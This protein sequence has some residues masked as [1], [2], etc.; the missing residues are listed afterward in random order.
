MINLQ[1]KALE[2]VE[3]SPSHYKVCF[4]FSKIESKMT[5]LQRYK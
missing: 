4:T 3:T 2:E 5:S 1:I